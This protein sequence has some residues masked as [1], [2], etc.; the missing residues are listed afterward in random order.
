MVAVTKKPANGGFFNESEN[1]SHLF[2]FGFLVNY[3]FADLR[4]EFANLDLL[5]MEPLVLSRRVE[6]P[7]SCR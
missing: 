3:M 1:Q 4:V 6:M 5:R 7:G 2:D